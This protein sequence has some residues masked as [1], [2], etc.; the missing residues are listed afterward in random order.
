MYSDKEIVNR[1][2][3]LLA[4]KGVHHVVISP[5]S[6][7]APLIKSLTAHPEIHCHSI[8]DERSA[9]Y[10]ALGMSLSL[11]A[12]IALTCTSGTAMLNYAPALSEAFYQRVPL[13]ALTADRPGELIDQREGQA[14]RQNNA[15]HNF[16]K[17]EATLPQE[18]LDEDRLWYGERLIAEAINQA[19]TPA[20]GP[21]HLN[22]PL[23][24]PLYGEQ[25][26]IRPAKN[27]GMS[28]AQ[29]QL[30]QAEV[31]TLARAWSKTRRVMILTGVL[32][33]D[34]ELEEQLVKA[35]QEPNTVVLTER[36]SNLFHPDF[37][38]YIDRSLNTMP[39]S[40]VEA[41]KPDLLI[42]IG[43]DVVSKQI[44]AF[45]RKHK[46]KSHWHIDDGKQH[47][48]TYKSL[49][50]VV[51]VSPCIFLQSVLPHLKS[52]ESDYSDKWEGLE[53]C[54]QQVHDQYLESTE[55]SDLKAFKSLMKDIPAPGTLHL[56]N[57]TPVRYAM[58]F[59]PKKGLKY[60]ANR[61]T[62]G[63]DGI[64][65]TAAGYASQSNEIN[66]V[67]TGDVSFY[68][69]SNALWNK[70]LPSNLRIIV[71]NNQGGSI[72]RIIPGP[73]TTGKMEEFF[74]TKQHFE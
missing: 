64:V 45:L 40:D 23:R 60:L 5:G 21:V 1:L 27:I 35:S 69:D 7:N 39:A 70:H 68:Y 17:F 56:G 26:S 46:S 6:R 33:P 24:E 54:G 66:T 13:I 73:A 25:E 41:Y 44:K 3:A 15:Y 49:T 57:S 12:P 65:S 38:H 34:S 2:V 30:S 14:I 62:S 28:F 58:L 71:I 63:I 52:K 51:P 59:A 47:T 53:S 42:T 22:I 50:Q 10:Y 19:V 36:T 61:G 74:E 48:D 31:I 43:T 20:K 8:V 72:F 55:W 67:I 16:I 18:P 9:G 4:A 11:N 32:S 29:K 37:H